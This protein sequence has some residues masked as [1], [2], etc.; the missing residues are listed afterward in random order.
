MRNSLVQ[1]GQRHAGRTQPHMHEHHLTKPEWVWSSSVDG[2]L[3]DIFFR[4][5][6]R[7]NQMKSVC[8]FVA[9]PSFPHRLFFVCFHWWLNL[10]Q[11]HL[12]FLRFLNS[13]PILTYCCISNAFSET[14][15]GDQCLWKWQNAKFGL[16]VS[17]SRTFNRSENFKRKK[18]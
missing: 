4:S 8:C 14:P 15:E 12:P 11:N 2:N 10:W 3:N 17:L 6:L 16:Q 13:M 9:T 1:S 7:A 5:G 18:N